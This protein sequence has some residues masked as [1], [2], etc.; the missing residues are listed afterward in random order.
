M[1]E[2]GLLSKMRGDVADICHICVEE[3]KNT[4]RDEGVLI[5]F[6]LVPLFYPLLYSWI[7]NNEVARDVPVVVVDDS[8]SALSREFI[9]RCDA[10]P[11]VR[12]LCHANDMDEARS[13]MGRQAVRGIYYL[14]PDFSVR[15]NRMER[16]AVSVY[17]D[18]SLM[19][20][21]KAV[22]QTAMSVS[23]EMN[24]HIQVAL[25]G[26]M[27]AREDELTTSPLAF[28]AVPIYNPSGGYGSFVLPAVLM[29]ILQ[30]TLVLGIGLSAGTARERNRYSDLIPFSRRYRGMFRIVFGKGLCYFIIYAVLGAYL[31]MVVPR[32]FDFVVL[33]SPSALLGVML[34]YVL[35]CIFFG[36]TVSCLVRYRENVMLLVVFTSV[37]LLFLSGVSW[38]QSNMP[39]GWECVSWLFPSTFGIRAYVRVNTMGAML[40]EVRVEYIALW[41]QAAV[42]FILACVVY[43]YQIVLSKLH[44][45]ERLERLR[46]KREVRRL[47]RENIV[48]R[49]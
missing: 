8:R 29:L 13:L 6:I 21:Y 20:N 19:L 38:P 41:F 47:L 34:P 33:A 3:M 5:F 22:Y 16:T 11:D 24:A 2:N 14:P 35:A 12:V 4:V 44:V 37:P 45:T 18:M 31:S 17:C 46:R 43:R 7:Y 27:T 32:L 15:V 26:N 9:R 30:Q 1:R 10:S 28:T 48:R 23:Q 36:M 42:Y 39:W 40:P 49:G 25:A